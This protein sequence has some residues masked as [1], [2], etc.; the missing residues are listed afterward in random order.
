MAFDDPNHF[1]ARPPAQR[2]SG[3]WVFGEAAPAAAPAQV[4]DGSLL[5]VGDPP[6]D[7]DAIFVAPD[8]EALGIPPASME[9][10]EALID[11]L[12]FEPAMMA[13]SVIAACTWF[14]GRD[15]AAHLKLAEDVFGTGRPI[16]EKLQ[17]FVAEGPNH[18]IFNEQHLIVLMRLMITGGASAEDG[19]RELSDEEVELLLM[20]LV[21]VATPIS[22][23]G[24]SVA[25]PARPID[26][27]PFLVRSGLYFDKRNLG[28]E[29]GR[30][31]ALFV[32][33][34]GA[35]DREGHR[36]CDLAA[37]MAEDLAPIEEQLGFAYAMGVWARAFD[38]DPDLAERKI[39]IVREGLLAGQLS[40][41][42]IEGLVAAISADRDE[43]AERFSQAGED[44]DHVI[45]D[46][47]PFEQRPFLR[48]SDGRMI[49]ISPRFL[50]GWMGE[51]F[52]YRLLDSAA[53]R[54][55]P[56]ST[57]TMSRRFTEFHGELMERYVL[58]LTAESHR[59]QIRAGLATVSGEQRYI[60]AD[61]SE[62]LSPDVLIAY[63][64]ELLAIEVTGGRPARRAR[65]ISDPAEMLEVIGRVVEKM[66]E[67]D[68][69]ISNILAGLVAI[70]GL[71]SSGPERVWP[72]VIVPSTI[73]QSEMLWDYIGAEAPS[74]FADARVQPP[75]LLSI[76][77]YEQAL[78]L[79]ESGK[80]LPALLGERLGSVYRRMPPSHFLDAQRPRPGRPSFLDRHTKQAGDDAAAR[81]FAGDGAALGDT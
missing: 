8:A 25:D 60:G 29:Q 66:R 42:R 18:L 10:V 37:W 62:S 76:E 47:V 44:I 28:S 57:R 13:L 15:Q 67:L 68:S 77:D 24:D 3:L 72:V 73:L 54:Q 45:W 39:A 30:A 61:G 14:L 58:T 52:Y 50:Y 65:I 35:A 9:T 23:A 64:P 4:P 69:A 17:R 38:Q 43:F 6:S 31:H 81:L 55:L 51:G 78:G 27:V 49:L 40:E 36:W 26:W 46:G 75:T 16:F 71:T 53:A 2:L 11:N 74:L 1:F 56:G 32:E 34:F 80:G 63:G 70:E 19:M 20:A 5:I 79:V 7:L 21:G 12:P 22:T 59:D 33:H 41:E 48:L